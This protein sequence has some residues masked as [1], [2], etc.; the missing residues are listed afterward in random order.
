MQ[1]L[2]YS[3]DLLYFIYQTFWF[4]FCCGILSLLFFHRD[5]ISLLISLEL[6]LLGVMS[7]FCFASVCNYDLY[8]QIAALVVLVLAGADS[9]LGLALVVMVYRFR[10]SI[11]LSQLTLLRG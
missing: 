3:V 11:S 5:F 7:L 1:S 4:I 6:S 9:A 10:G 8:G 2:F